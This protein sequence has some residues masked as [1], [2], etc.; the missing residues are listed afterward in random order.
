MDGAQVIGPI[1]CSHG[2][3]AGS[4]PPVRC[5]ERVGHGDLLTSIRAAVHADV[6]PLPAP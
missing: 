3:R 6:R 2:G 1:R 4:L 5:A